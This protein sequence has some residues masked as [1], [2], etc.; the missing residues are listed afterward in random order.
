M[1]VLLTRRHSILA[2]NT[3]V[4]ANPTVAGVGS[5]I[6]NA[7]RGSSS[8]G[9]GGDVL[10]KAAQA[11][12]ALVN[13][14]THPHAN[15]IGKVSA[16]ALVSGPANNPIHHDGVQVLVQ[17]EER[18]RRLQQASALLQKRVAA[19]ARADQQRKKD[20]AVAEVRCYLH[21]PPFLT[22]TFSSITYLR[23][24]SQSPHSTP[25]HPHPLHLLF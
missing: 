22:S 5:S 13:Q 9:M 25:P 15:T 2:T 4:G 14:A 24:I 12:V 7:G 18:S 17:D 23:I 11:A 6:G 20:E 3:D 16:S 10:T 19:R 1:M 8:G 21:P